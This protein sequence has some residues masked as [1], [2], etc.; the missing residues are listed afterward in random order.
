M[1]LL[2]LQTVTGI[3]EQNYLFWILRGR[4]NVLYICLI[5]LNRT[6]HPPPKIK[7]NANPEKEV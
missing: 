3:V 7:I 5:E 2:L 1:K 4:I 6:I